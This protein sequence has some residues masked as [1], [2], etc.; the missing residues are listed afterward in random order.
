MFRSLVISNAPVLLIIQQGAS[1]SRT[2]VTDILNAALMTIRD[3]VIGAEL[4]IVSD[5]KHFSAS[6][7]L[8]K[9]SQGDVGGVLTALE[10][11]KLARALQR[12][13]LPW[14]DG[15]VPSVPQEGQAGSSYKTLG[16]CT[17]SN[18]GTRST[19]PQQL[20]VYTGGGMS[21]E[22]AEKSALQKGIGVLYGGTLLDWR[23]I[24]PLVQWMCSK[25]RSSTALVELT[26]A[27][28]ERCGHSG[29]AKCAGKLSAIVSVIS[30]PTGGVLTPHRLPVGLPQR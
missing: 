21:Q 3:S 30:K 16:P 27:L 29:A 11:L 14:V 10:Q 18:L 19:D 7:W 22:R 12:R 28:L 6:L 24:A 17:Y 2:P 23:H 4:C 20:L 13:Q 26:G 9:L 8:Q 15:P 5:K 1:V 25:G